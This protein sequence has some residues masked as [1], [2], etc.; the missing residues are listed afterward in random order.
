MDMIEAANGRRATPFAQSVAAFFED[1]GLLLKKFVFRVGPQEG[2]AAF[3]EK[4]RP[5]FPEEAST[6]RPLLDCPYTPE[7]NP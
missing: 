7:E 3:L 2:L 4:R 5:R 1:D 6:V